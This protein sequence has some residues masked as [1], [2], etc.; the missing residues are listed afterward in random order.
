MTVLVKFAIEISP[1]EV[2]ALNVPIMVCS[3]SEESME[4]G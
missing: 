2:E 1:V 3:D 4:A